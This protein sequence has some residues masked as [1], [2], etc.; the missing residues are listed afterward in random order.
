MPE[1][2]HRDPDLLVLGRAI[3][4]LREQRGM[5]ADELAGAIAIPRQ[6]IDALER[7]RL[8]PTY[9]L[10]L[11]LAEGLGVQASAVVSLAERLK[12]SG[13]LGG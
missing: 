4:R 2:G 10:L 5:S 1:G 6:R 3:R 13:E 11:E 9:E 8:D 7:G 12:R